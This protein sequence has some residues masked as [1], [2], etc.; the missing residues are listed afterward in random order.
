MLNSTYFLHSVL[1]QIEEE[2]KKMK[3]DEEEEE[4]DFVGIKP[5]SS[6][7]QEGEN[8]V[9]CKNQ[10]IGKEEKVGKEEF[11]LS[12]TTAEV[13][14]EVKDVLHNVIEAVCKINHSNS[15]KSEPGKILR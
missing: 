7:S 1:I 9:L 6:C 5:Q 4:I 13:P 2:E 8:F 14:S 15:Y 11:L 3:E 12:S 10:T